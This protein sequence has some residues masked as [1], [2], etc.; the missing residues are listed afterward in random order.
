MLIKYLHPIG[1]IH[2]MNS[3]HQMSWH[4][5]GLFLQTTGYIHKKR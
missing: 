4:F 5:G 2:P 1:F 3:S